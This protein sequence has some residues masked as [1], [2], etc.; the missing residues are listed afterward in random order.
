MPVANFTVIDRL[1]DRKY[2]KR[3]I[4]IAAIANGPQWGTVRKTADDEQGSVVSFSTLTQHVVSK[5]TYHKFLLASQALTF[6]PLCF[7]PSG[8]YYEG[9]FSFPFCLFRQPNNL[10]YRLRLMCMDPLDIPSVP[11]GPGR[12]GFS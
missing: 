3:E 7:T 11:N 5:C 10:Y 12:P 4:K 9:R 2:S 6:S 8:A 1:R